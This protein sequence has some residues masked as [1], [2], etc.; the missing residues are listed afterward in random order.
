MLTFH[1]YTQ[2][3]RISQRRI[4]AAWHDLAGE[5]VH[6]TP[7]V[8]AQAAEGALIAAPPG[9]ARSWAEDV[10]RMLPRRMR[11]AEHSHPRYLRGGFQA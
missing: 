7:T 3:I 10:R 9:L 2:L 5:T 1:D 11:A 8:A 4:T 6:V